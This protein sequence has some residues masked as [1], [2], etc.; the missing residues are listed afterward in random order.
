MSLRGSGAGPREGGE[1]ILCE[2]NMG[3][4]HSSQ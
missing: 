2:I 4:L 3:L 1:A